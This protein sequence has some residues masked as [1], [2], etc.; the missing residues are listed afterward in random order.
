MSSLTTKVL[1]FVFVNS[2]LAQV[3]SFANNRKLNRRLCTNSNKPKSRQMSVDDFIINETGEDK[4]LAHSALAII[5]ACMKISTKISRAAIDSNIGYLSSSDVNS[6]GDKQKKLDVL[7]DEL[8]LKYLKD[9]ALDSKVMLYASEENEIPL[10]L[11]DDGELVVICDP[12]DGSSN[13]DC[14]IPTG[15]IFG[16]FRLKESTRYALVESIRYHNP[17]LN[18]G[19]FSKI[20]I[21]AVLQSDR[22]LSESYQLLCSGYVMYSGSTELMLTFGDGAHGFTLDRLAND[23]N[24]HQF[25]MTRKYVKCPIRG[26]YYSL[27]E[28]R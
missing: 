24:K 19:D 22:E 9:S 23:I 14:A 18:S 17:I 4:S 13:I 3:I 8:I 27:N 20:L 10:V 12:L 28:G 7:S 15:T 11:N 2:F 6:T 26:Q 1:I 5:Q 21:K 16:I 25:V